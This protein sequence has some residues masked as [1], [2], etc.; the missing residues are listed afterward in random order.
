V[1]ELELVEDVTI[2]PDISVEELIELYG[3]I[4]GFMAGHLY[5]AIRIL[6]E[7]LPESKI[8]ILS[9]TAN[10]VSTGLRGILAQLVREGLFNV[11]ITTCGTLDHDIARAEGGKYLKGFFEADDVKLY[12]E[13]YHRLGNIFIPIEDYGLKVESFVRRLV[14]EAIKIKERWPLYELLWLA[15]SLIKDRNSILRAAYN[16]KVPVFVPGW[17]DGAFGTAVFME[18][19]RGNR[20]LIDYTEDMKKLSDIF[21][22]K[23]GKAVGLLIG[24]GISKHHAIWW[25]QFRDGLDYVVYITTA[26]EYDG[27]LSG[28]HPREAITWG[29]VKSG[30]RKVVV[31]GDVTLLLPI[32]A[33]GLLNKV[34]V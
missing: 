25:S 21:F 5:E 34:K 23:E 31:Y 16:A 11:V 27:S 19:Q 6:R 20:I 33:V 13:G 14:E 3:K 12:E 28:A 22:P 9:F 30:A 26:V 17:P 29:K 7:A 4:H 15:G 10:I 24:G 18:A 8:R 32:I 2:Y 1:K